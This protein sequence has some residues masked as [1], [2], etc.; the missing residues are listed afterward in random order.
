MKCNYKYIDLANNEA[1]TIHVT[2][3]T[4]ISRWG[5]RALRAGYAGKGKLA[6]HGATTLNGLSCITV[7]D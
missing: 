7:I 2:K 4:H 1:I 6:F 5:R 3:A